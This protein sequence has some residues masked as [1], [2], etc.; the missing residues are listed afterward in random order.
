M[1]TVKRL[2]SRNSDEGYNSSDLSSNVSSPSSPS[3]DTAKN[4]ARDVKLF[5]EKY[6]VEKLITNSANGVIYKGF[7]FEILKLKIGNVTKLSRWRMI[8]RYLIKRCSGY[9]KSDQ[10][11]VVIKQIPKARVTNWAKHGDRTIPKEFEMHING[12]HARGVVQIYDWFERRT[13]YIH[14]QPHLFY[15]S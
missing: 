10:K 1:A 12:Q 7:Q 8:A 9:R 15:K 14:N 5:K 6:F 3:R 2:S 11:S 13:R 4:I